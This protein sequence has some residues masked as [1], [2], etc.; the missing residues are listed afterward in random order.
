[1]LFTAAAVKRFSDANILLQCI[2]DL[3]TLYSQD[4]LLWDGLK[5]SAMYNQDWLFCWCLQ[6]RMGGTVYLDNAFELSLIHI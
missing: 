5:K 2:D 6:V 3:E 1:M 4:I